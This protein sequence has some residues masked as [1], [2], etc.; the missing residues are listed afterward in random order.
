MSTSTTTSASDPVEANSPA[1]DITSSGTSPDETPPASDVPDG[2]CCIC[3]DTLQSAPC[4]RLECGHWCHSGCVITWFRSG[5]TCP[6]CRDLP[7]QIWRYPTVYERASRLRSFSRRKSAPRALKQIVK[8]LKACESKIKSVTTEIAAYRKEPEYKRVRR[9]L[10]TRTSMRW[11]LQ[12]KRES[13]RNE[14][15]LFDAPDAALPVVVMTSLVP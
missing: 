9:E 3:M 14:L 15:A 7:R 5:N 13:I 1:S 6:L 12:R 8:R 10:T 2:N 4:A 11:K